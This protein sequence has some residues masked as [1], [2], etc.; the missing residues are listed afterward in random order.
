MRYFT[1]NELCRSDYA[2]AHGIPNNPTSD[3]ITSLEL[4]THAVLDP[5]RERF[6]APITVNSGYRNP[7]L[8]KLVGGVATSQHT[9][10]EAVDLRTGSK[11]GNKRLYE[12]IR[13]N[14]EF[15]QLI[16]EHDFS[17]VHVSYRH[18]NNRNQ[19]LTIK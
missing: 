16:N 8:N 1:I 11:E 3:I 4:L 15:D 12:I 10:G 6:G 9:K 17:W 18:A 7:R 13:D 19:Q 5:A 14:C 2:V